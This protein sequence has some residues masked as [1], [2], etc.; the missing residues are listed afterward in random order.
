MIENNEFNSIYSLV[1][2][3]WKLTL[4]NSRALK[5][6]EL[7]ECN[8]IK[9]YHNHVSDGIHKSL[10]PKKARLFTRE[11]TDKILSMEMHDTLKNYLGEFIVSDEE[12]IGYPNIYWR[13]VRPRKGEDIGPVHRDEWF[14]ILNES[15]KMP[16]NY[17]R[18]K[19]W[20]PLAIEEG[21][22]GLLVEDKSHKRLDIK[23]KG[24]E[25][26]GIM[27]PLLLTSEKY[28]N[29]KLAKTNLGDAVIF[30]DRLLHG[31]KLNTGKRTRVSVE[32]TVLISAD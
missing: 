26:H 20:I 27:K 30:H 31:G 14:W 32:F 6:K 4:K 23:W 3:K 13:L 25:R 7:K 5:E 29:L 18:V 19:V 24:E 2:K 15:Y 9:Y 17:R 8:D 22:S 10:W 11:E 12:N 28:L 21:E 16:R 1:E